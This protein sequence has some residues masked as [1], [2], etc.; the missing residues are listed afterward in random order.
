MAPMAALV[1]G[2]VWI[3]GCNRGE[4]AQSSP[5]TEL[6][7][8]ERRDLDVRAEAS[9]TIEPIRIVEVKSKASGEILNLPVET[10]DVVTVGALLAEIDPRDV[11]NAHEQAKADLQVAE[12]RYQTAVAQRQRTE[13]LLQAS[14]VTQQELESARLEEANA[15][16]QLIKARTNLQLAEERL[17]DVTIRAPIAGVIISR[18]VEIGTII[19]SASGNVSGGTVLMTMADLSSMQVRALIDETDLGKI[20]PGM[21]VQVSVEAYPERR[22]SGEVIKIEP[23]AVIDQ[24]VT[25]FPVLVELDNRESLLKVG[26]NADVQIMIAHRS[27]VI[28]V[29]SSAVV[30]TRD[31]VTAGRVLGLDEQAVRLAMQAPTPE[32]PPVAGGDTA[33]GEAPAPQQPQISAECQQLMARAREQ[34]LQ[35]LSE[36]DRAKMRECRPQGQRGMRGNRGNRGGRNG[37]PGRQM[38]PQEGVV[39]VAKADGSYEP[40][41]VTLGVNDFEFTEVVRGLE[42][43][44]QVVIVSVAQ[45]QQAQQDFLQRMRD[46]AASQGPIPSG[47][48]GMRGR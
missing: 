22:F 45:L 44:E 27:D 4:A 7:V 23:Q 14:V 13:E 18:P 12:A 28:V 21:P 6:A 42:P 48:P 26:M 31:A 47:G 34:G 41:H 9:G 15:N 10:G 24:N 46:R 3:A 17:N 20:S 43:G 33:S 38:A 11:R 2:S 37:G 5:N 25:M 40:R 36:A 1:L 35:N 16:A 19:A 39:F 29:P 30:S 32:P 8:V